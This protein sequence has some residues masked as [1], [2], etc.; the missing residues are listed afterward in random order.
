MDFDVIVLGAGIVGVSCALHLQDR[1]RRV[2]LVD[3][4]GPGEETSFGNA[5]LIESS[6]IVPYGFPRRLG[7]LLRYARNQSTDLY[8][9]YRA[10]PAFAGWLGRFWWESSPKRLA[11]AARDMLPL[12]R[13]SVAEHDVLIARAGLERLSHDGGWIEAFRTPSELDGQAAAAQAAVRDYGLRVTPLDATALRAK[14]PGIGAGF[15][16]ALHWHDPKSISDPGALTKGYAGLFE[17]TGGTLLTGDAATL[18][19]QGEVW[20]VQTSAGEISAKEVVVA[21]GPWSDTVFEPLGYRIP[22]RA[23]RGYHMHYRPT[24]TVLSVPVVDTEKGYVIAPMQ[25][26]L[27]L[28]TGVEIANRDAAPSPVQLERAERIAKTLFGL[29]ERLDE[30][31]WLGRRPCTP[32]M[33]PV[34][35]RAPRHRGLWFAFGHNHHGLTLGPVT[36]RLLA[37][38]MTGA[39]PFIDMRPFRPE[40]FG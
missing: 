35:G 39:E 38:M 21:L 18:R 17:Q 40:R 19:A 1:G 10:L 6:S 22:L 2:A 14:E 37:E 20:T 15:C 3:R 28:T 13:Q 30:T 26:G 23:K 24:G 16:G 29:G 5:G 25:A 34:I 9:D 11:M 7:T 32:D 12:I 31:P 33:R 36:G 8:W 27:R 4:R